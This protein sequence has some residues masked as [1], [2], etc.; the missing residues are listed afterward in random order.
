MQEVKRQ[1]L[2]HHFTGGIDIPVHDTAKS[3]ADLYQEYPHEEVEL[4]FNAWGCLRHSLKESGDRQTMNQALTT[5]EALEAL[6]AIHI[7]EANAR[8]QEDMDRFMNFKVSAKKHPL[9]FLNEMFELSRRINKTDMEV[10]ESFVLYRFVGALPDSEYKLSK[11]LLNNLKT[12]TREEVVRVVT[13]F[14]TL[15]KE[16]AGKGGRGSEQ[17]YVADG[18]RGSRFSNR[19]RGRGGG[20]TFEGRCHTCGKKGHMSRCSTPKSEYLQQCAHC[21]GWGHTTDECPTETAVVAEVVEEESETDSLENVAYVA[22]EHQQ[23]KCGHVGLVG[24][25]EQ[26]RDV[27][28][29]VA[30]TAASCSMFTSADSFVKYLEC[31]GSLKGISGTTSPIQGYGDVTVFFRS[32]NG[33][34]PVTLKHVAHTP[35]LQYNLVSISTLAEE[36][37]TYLG[38]KGGI[39]LTTPGGGEVWFPQLPWPRP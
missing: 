2:M 1:N 32:N 23:G 7:P 18:G 21:A 12:L 8:A 15:T 19:G 26:G 24:V 10:N 28:R 9:L 36:G 37:H 27:M 38:K 16:R 31:S 34:S 30:D 20:K 25:T 39:V 11:Y 29:Y 13:Q 14:A 35:E 6:K 17:A 33:W 3:K 5:R 4:A 22:E